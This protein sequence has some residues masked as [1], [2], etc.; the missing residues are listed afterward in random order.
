MSYA[1]GMAAIKL[2]FSDR[3]P[4][5]EYSVEMHYELMSKVTGIQV[6]P[7]SPP[8]L[9]NKVRAIFRKEWSLDFAW[10]VLVSRQYLKGPTS[11]MGHAVYQADASDYNTNTYTAFNSPQSVYKIDMFDLYGTIDHKTMVDEFNSHYRN[12]CNYFTDMVNMTGIYITCISGMIDMFGWEMLLLALGED[13][14][15]F[16][17]FTN[18]YANWIQ[19]HYNALADC[20]A[21]VVMVHDDMVWTEGAF[22]HPAWYRKYVFPN[23][24]KFWSPLVEAGKKVIFCSDGTFTEFIDDLVDCGAQGFVLEPTTDIQ[25]IADHYGKTHVIVGNADTRILL[26]GSK[27]DIY[28]EVKRCM[29]IGK[30]YPGFFMAVGNHIPANTPVDNALWYNECYEK[31]SRR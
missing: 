19:Q 15:A 3:V 14:V 29:D 26:D 20:E 23:Y 21:D 1:D 6:A 18:R 16:G 4:R 13:P 28:N 24:K 11:Y 31:M 10:N 17:E 2:E 30:K 12:A 9:L 5:T 8:E 25:Y 22:A 7:D 27:E